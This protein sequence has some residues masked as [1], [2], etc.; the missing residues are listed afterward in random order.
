M[1]VLVGGVIFAGY[2]A[3]FYS[4]QAALLYS[5]SILWGF[6]NATMSVAIS[7]FVSHNSGSKRY[8]ISLIDLTER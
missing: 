6:G 5:A 7:I 2:M 1:A 8:K 4:L 3:T